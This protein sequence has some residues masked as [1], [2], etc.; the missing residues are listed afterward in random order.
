MKLVK[1]YLDNRIQITSFNSIHSNIQ[2]NN[3]GVNQGS[4]LGSLLFIIYISDLLKIVDNDLNKSILLFD[5]DTSLTVQT[6][7]ILL[8]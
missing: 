5:D 4:V 7:S 8:L 2:Y 1:S 3:I 6:I